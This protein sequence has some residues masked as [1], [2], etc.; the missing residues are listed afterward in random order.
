MK[1]ILGKFTHKHLGE[2]IWYDAVIYVDTP[3]GQ[4]YVVNAYRPRP[5]DDTG[6]RPDYD[7]EYRARFHGVGGEVYDGVF[8]LQQVHV[9]PGVTMPDYSFVAVRPDNVTVT[10]TVACGCDD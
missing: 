8:R 2:S 1:K 5:F 3:K 9:T 7:G 4:K 6:F 10:T